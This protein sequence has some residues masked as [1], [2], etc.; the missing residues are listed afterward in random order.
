VIFRLFRTCVIKLPSA[1]HHPQFESLQRGETMPGFHPCYQWRERPPNWHV[2]QICISHRKLQSLDV[3]FASAAIIKCSV[4]LR[5]VTYRREPRC[6]CKATTHVYVI[7][8]AAPALFEK[9]TVYPQIQLLL[10]TMGDIALLKKAAFFC[11]RSYN[12]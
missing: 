2:I 10:R 6:S 12:Q 8:G 5:R 3:R 4:V 11:T 7:S 9:C 1:S